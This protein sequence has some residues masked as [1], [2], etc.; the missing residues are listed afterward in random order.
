M[1]VELNQNCLELPK[2][3]FA[4]LLCFEI[5]SQCISSGSS[6]YFWFSSTTIITRET[7]L[8][9]TLIITFAK[10]SGRLGTL[11]GQS[12]KKAEGVFADGLEKF[13]YD[14]KSVEKFVGIVE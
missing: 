6:K 14:P 5:H 1:V 9:K 11:R 7:K 2:E 13:V 4:D 8:L 10:R 3:I 12:Q